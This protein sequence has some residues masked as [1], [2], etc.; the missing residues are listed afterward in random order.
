MVVGIYIYLLEKY[1]R[2]FIVNKDRNV[3][4][5][6]FFSITTF[7]QILWCV[8]AKLD[9]GFESRKMKKS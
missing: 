2:G 4:N 9:F 1:V 3:Y 5:V 8:D 7:K 6:E